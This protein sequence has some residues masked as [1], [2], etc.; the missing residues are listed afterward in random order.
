MDKIHYLGCN[1]HPT[2]AFSTD[3]WGTFILLY[4]IIFSFVFDCPKLCAFSTANP[5]GFTFEV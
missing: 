2:A 4:F 3:E 5:G 1:K